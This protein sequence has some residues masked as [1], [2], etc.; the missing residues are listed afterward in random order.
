MVDSLLDIAQIAALNHIA[1]KRCEKRGGK[2]GNKIDPY[3]A[4]GM[5]MI[6]DADAL[7]KFGGLL[8]A[9]GAFDPDDELYIDTASCSKPRDNRYAWR[10][11]CADGSAYGISPYD[12]ET[13]DAYNIAINRAKAIKQDSTEISSTEQPRKETLPE[14]DATEQAQP[15][16][17]YI[18][19]CSD[20]FA[21]DD[22]HVYIYCRVKLADSGRIA[23]YRTEDQTVK[24]GEVVIGPALNAKKNAQGEVLSVERHLRFSV[25]QPVEQTLEIVGRV[26]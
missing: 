23:Y 10:L 2:R 18:A 9:M 15:A 25:P 13:Q 24:K 19:S 22:F 26:T 14:E 11:N 20:P 12:Y 4:T 16:E 5:A 1:N 8:G 3:K 6:K 7:I 17:N 21:Y